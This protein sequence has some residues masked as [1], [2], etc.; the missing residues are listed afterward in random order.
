VSRTALS[1]FSGAGGLD[2]GTERAGFRTVGAIESAPIARSTLL[3]NAQEFFPHLTPETV[4]TD[5]T[6]VPP[7]AVL[8]RT[9]LEPGETDLVHGGPPCVA[10]SKTGYWLPYK[11]EDRDEKATLVDWF[12][13]MAART[14]PRAILMENVYG[15]A[16][17]R[18]RHHLDRFLAGMDEAGYEVRWRVLLAADH[19][20]PQIRQRLFC[21]GVR[22]D[23]LDRDARRW[24]FPWPEPTHSGPHETRRRLREDLPRHVTAGE[25]LLGLAAADN[26]P[27]PEEVVRGSFERELAEVPP[28]ENYLYFTA[29]RGHPEPRWEWRSRYWSFLL[30]ASPGAPVPTIQGQPGPWVGPFHWEGRRFRTAELKRL[31][32][33]PD[34][35]EILGTRRERQLQLGNAV[36][37]KLAQIVAGAIARELDRLESS[38]RELQL[39][40]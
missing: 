18:S 9:G 32:T 23:L 38:P 5:I 26:P 20:V 8:A 34:G 7:D 13:G 2:V 29:R 4:F 27:E 6:E 11:R 22:R 31:M 1:L 35:F 21:V 24:I 3:R 36:P 33:F 40:A 17:K 19:G 16:Y 37:P 28:G 10:F 25:A 39:A 30:K 14:R 15:L 12:V